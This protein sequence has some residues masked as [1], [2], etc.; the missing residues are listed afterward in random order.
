MQTKAT[1]ITGIRF[2]EA[3]CQAVVQAAKARDY[4]SSSAFMRASVEK[5]LR[6]THETLDES[7]HRI[8]AWPDN[9]AQALSLV[10]FHLSRRGV[11][12]SGGLR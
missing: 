4:A 10:G 9:G 2:S 11:F 8:S 5:E 1:R 7:E 3:T 6:G 12:R